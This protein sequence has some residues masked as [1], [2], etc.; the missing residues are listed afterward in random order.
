MT[1]VRNL[2]RR[3]SCLRQQ[4]PASFV[5][6]EGHTCN[7]L[8]EPTQNSDRAQVI[9]N[10]RSEASRETCQCEQET[11]NPGCFKTQS[12]TLWTWYKSP[13]STR[14]G[15]I[16][17][18][19]PVN[20]DKLL[21]FKPGGEKNHLRQHSSSVLWDRERPHMDWQHQRCTHSRRHLSSDLAQ[22][23]W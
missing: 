16:F 11:P 10:S 19:L 6:T 2:S 1:C 18:C 21:R 15:N 3:R 23:V 12:A 22:I 17:L 13:P 7:T 5:W 4:K 14:T 9:L 20:S 8:K